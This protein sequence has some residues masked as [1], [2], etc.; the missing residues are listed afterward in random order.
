M[1]LSARAGRRRSFQQAYCASTNS[2]VCLI[3]SSSSCSGGRPSG[4]GVVWPSSMRCSRPARR[5]S[6]NSSRFDAV[7]LRN[8]TR[9]RSGLFSSSASSKTRM[10]N[11]SQ[12]TSRFR[13]Y[14]ALSVERGGILRC[15]GNNDLS[16]GIRKESVSQG[17]PDGN[18]V[19]A[20]KFRYPNAHGRVPLANA[21]LLIPTHSFR[22]NLRSTHPCAGPL[23][24]ESRRNRVSSVSH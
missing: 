24:C 21:D 22:I 18:F 15:K 16:N 20:L 7:M 13:K 10:L 4:P 19:H 17:A 14:S 23:V 12:E 11:L 3:T 2:F 9:S 8:F 6:K 5:T 1:P